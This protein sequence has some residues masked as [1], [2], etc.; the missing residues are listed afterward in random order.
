MLWE[1]A[2]CISHAIIILKGSFYF[3]QGYFRL[4]LNLIEELLR[5]LQ[6]RLLVSPVPNKMQSIWT[7][8]FGFVKASDQKVI[9]LFLSSSFKKEKNKLATTGDV[10]LSFSLSNNKYPCACLPLVQVQMLKEQHGVMLFEDTAVL[11]KEIQA[12]DD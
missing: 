8:K 4:L 5:L 6:V 11:V 12:V 2:L 1:P 3:G 9:S 7:D 10:L